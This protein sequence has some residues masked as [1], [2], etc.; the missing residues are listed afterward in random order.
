M[1][2]KY[3]A[4]A[5]FFIIGREA[6]KYPD[7]VVDIVRRGHTL[8]NHSF[9]HRNFARLTK[10]SQIA[11]ILRTND[12]IQSITG[13]TTHLFRVPRGRWSITLLLLVR[14]LKMKAIHWS[15]DSLDYTKRPASFLTQN[16]IDNGIRPGDILLFHDDSEL[17]LD[18]MELLLP[19]L[20]AKGFSFAP[21]ENLI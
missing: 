6:Q 13:S 20:S 2:D 15:I 7:I 21:M 5:T 17:C 11:E 16:I 14:Q 18:I 1:L 10:A 4:K 3:D 9:S 12:Q 8:A 19:Q